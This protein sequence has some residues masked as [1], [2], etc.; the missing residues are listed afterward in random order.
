MGQNGFGVL[1]EDNEVLMKL[2]DKC[3]IGRHGVQNSRLG[4]RPPHRKKL[5]M[6]GLHEI[7]K[8]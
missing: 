5:V 4:G 6:Y 3:L 7:S 8:K 2:K 1:L